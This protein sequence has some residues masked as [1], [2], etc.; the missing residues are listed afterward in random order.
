[1]TQKAV[2]RQSND[3]VHHFEHFQRRG[4]LQ[5]AACCWSCVENRWQRWRQGAGSREHAGDDGKEDDEEEVQEVEEE[6]K[7]MKNES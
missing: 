4:G 2:L 7:K 3:K 1:M 5:F 6:E